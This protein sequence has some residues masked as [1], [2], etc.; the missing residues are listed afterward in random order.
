MQLSLI[1]DFSC[2]KTA[3][4]CQDPGRD[5]DNNTTHFDNRLQKVT[6]KNRVKREEKKN[7]EVQD[8]DITPGCDVQIELICSRK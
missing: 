6:E 1:N 5:T 3:T 7:R 8:V 2:C 4:T